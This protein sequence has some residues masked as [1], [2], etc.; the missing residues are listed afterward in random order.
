MSIYS[1]WLEKQFELERLKKDLEKIEQDERFKK[2]KAFKDQLES[3]MKE[4]DKSASDVLALIQ[5]EKADKAPV[6]SGPKRPLK[7]FKNPHTGEVVET[8]G[9]NQKTLKA[10]RE[11]YGKEAVASWQVQ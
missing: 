9:A 2:E 8:R 4:Y 1:V 7:I 5:P 6:K 10:W 11:E 3:L